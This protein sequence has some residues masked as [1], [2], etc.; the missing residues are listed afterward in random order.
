MSAARMFGG[1]ESL[2]R[3]VSMVVP[4]V[5]LAQIAELPPGAL[6]VFDRA[7]LQVEEITTDLVLRRAVAGQLSG[8]V[9]EEPPRDLPL[10][11]SWLAEK[12]GIGLILL[13]SVRAA[14][15]AAELDPHVRVPV[16]AAATALQRTIRAITTGANTPNALVFAL[17]QGLGLPATLVDLEGHTVHGT[18]IEPG[19]AML[20]AIAPGPVTE[21]ASRSLVVTDE[22]GV[23][24][25]LTP[26]AAHWPGGGNMW[27]VVQLPHTTS[28]TTDMAIAATQVASVAYAGYLAADALTAERE[29]TRR[30]VLLTEILEQGDEPSAQTVE[31]AASMQWR[32]HG[33]HLAVQ[34]L[35]K[36]SQ[37]ALTHPRVRGALEES[38]ARQGISARLVNRPGGWAFW[39]TYD[40]NPDP[41]QTRS[42]LAVVR[43]A[44]LEVERITPG[45]LLCAGVGSAE[46]GTAGIGRSLQSAQDTAMLARTRETA[47]AVE[48][49]DP[50]S[51][52]RML[53]GWYAQRPLQSIA[54]SLVDP[55]L[56]ADPSGELVH[57][58]RC[59]LDH[60]SNTSTTAAIL[61]V[62]RN[63]VLHRLSRIRGLLLAD[64]EKP[65]ERLAVHLALHAIGTDATPAG[66]RDP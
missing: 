65:E 53:L 61:G 27:F 26:A 63:T 50:L 10:S 48:H 56:S 59:Y 31:R 41:Q 39:A 47:A 38:L 60:E 15:L 46:Q 54:T 35:V 29:G 49:I 9:A 44:L 17:Q 64:L 66:H 2:A 24:I 18:P 52:K 30:A 36:Q 22:A 40:A 32:L 51:I 58:L 16:I 3:E 25:V 21:Q 1:P 20:T 8:V 11:T 34:V 43:R 55:L 37:G 28:V 23:Q 14:T 4:G 33:W 5:A 19:R 45:L 13:P 57:T 62:H 42:L 12:F 6:V 7:Q